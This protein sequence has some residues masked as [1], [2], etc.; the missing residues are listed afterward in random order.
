MIGNPRDNLVTQ[1]T[2]SSGV[3]KG[4]HYRFRYRARNVYG[5][6]PYSDIVTVLAAQVPA[7]AQTPTFDSAT[8]S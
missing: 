3:K 7:K 5:W 6:G 8:N 1:L 4:E 2:I